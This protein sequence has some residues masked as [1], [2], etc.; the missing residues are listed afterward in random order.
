M[1]VDGVF[2]IY[3]RWI[4]RFSVPGLCV[5]MLFCIFASS[6]VH[7][8]WKGVPAM[9][10]ITRCLPGGL[11]W[12]ENVSHMCVSPVNGVVWA[13]KRRKN[14]DFSKKKWKKFGS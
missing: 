6:F 11:W 3:I 4:R 10:R 8:A 12:L 2:F 9:A 5:C 13:Q 14:A 7:R 1:G